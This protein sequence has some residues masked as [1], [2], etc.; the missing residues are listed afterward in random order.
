M[1]LTEDLA[2]LGR[3]VKIAKNDTG[4]SGRC[5]NFLLAWW[6]AEVHGGFDLTNLWMLDVAIC[7]DMAL[8]FGLIARSNRYPDYYGFE[9]D[10]HAII[11]L[12]RPS[13]PD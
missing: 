11:D 2:A 1:S 9:K 4:Q 8:V 3:I 6:N 13:S 12:W 5:A 10:I 7:E